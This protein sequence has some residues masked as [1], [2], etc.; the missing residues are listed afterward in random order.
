MFQPL[1]CLVCLL[2]STNILLS[3]GRGDTVYV[4]HRK[5]TTVP[6]VNG[7]LV[8]LLKSQRKV[9]MFLSLILSSCFQPWHHRGG[10]GTAPWQLYQSAYCMIVLLCITGQLQPGNLNNTVTQAK[11]K[12]WQLKPTSW[13]EKGIL[14][15]LPSWKGYRWLMVAE[16]GKSVFSKD[17][18]LIVSPKGSELGLKPGVPI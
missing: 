6:S 9:T 3:G 4:P 2:C 15:G 17:K 16:M 14:T 13:L 7:S 18:S 11:S 5:M 10:T 1:T 8:T 12:K